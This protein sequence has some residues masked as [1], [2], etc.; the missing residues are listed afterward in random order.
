MD[1]FQNEQLDK[2]LQEEYERLVNETQK[3]GILLVGGTGVGKSSLCNMIFGENIAPTGM[4][5]PITQTIKKYES[6]ST[7]VRIYDSAGYECG[8]TEEF[9]NDVIELVKDNPAQSD[10]NIIWYCIQASGSKITDFDINTIKTL[11]DT[12]CPIC[13][14]LTKVD[15]SSDDDIRILRNTIA[16]SIIGHVPVF[17]TTTE[18]PEYNQAEELIAWSIEKLPDSLKMS[19]IKQQKCNLEQKRKHAKNAI[20]QHISTAGLIGCSPI[21][22][23][24]AP[25]LAANEMTLLARILYIYDLG[26]MQNMISS[27][28]IDFLMTALGKSIVGTIFKLIPGVGSVIGGMINS[29]V[30]VSLTWALGKSVCLA[31]EKIW[32]AKISGNNAELERIINNITPIIV[33]SAKN[34]LETKTGNEKDFDKNF[35]KRK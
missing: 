21:P 27:V 12:G 30:A 17:E 28:G 8:K 2:K 19:F 9:F 32:D 25:L 14:V 3:P 15:I 33:D 29:T 23:S 7:S 35:K 34:I 5:L 4:G 6:N 22:G 18:L 20:I 24:D 1:L 16:A 13:V 26:N 10:I 11:N 31:A